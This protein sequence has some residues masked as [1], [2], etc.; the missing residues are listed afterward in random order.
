M[1]PTTVR[2][3][4]GTAQRQRGKERVDQILSAAKSLFMADGYAG[5]SVRRVAEEAGISAGNLTYYFGSKAD[6]FQSM[7]DRVL[8]DYSDAL[9]RATSRGAGEPVEQLQNYLRELFADCAKP[10]TQRFFYQFWATAEHDAFVAGA[11]ERVY[12]TFEREL[13]GLLRPLNP[14]LAAGA[15]ARRVVLVMALVEGLHVVLGSTRRTRKALGELESE[16]LRQALAI[17]RA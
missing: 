4:D 8:E 13:T 6:L 7:I 12:A 2:V 9:S 17:I 16:F 15:L 5:L 11:R 10:D 3:R 14:D 1:Q